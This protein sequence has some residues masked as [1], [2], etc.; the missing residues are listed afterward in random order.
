MQHGLLRFIIRTLQRTA[1]IFG[2]HDQVYVLCASCE[3]DSR[4]ALCYPTLLIVRG[5]IRPNDTEAARRS[6]HCT[7]SLWSVVSLCAVQVC[8]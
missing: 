8:W 3:G 5:V 2:Q 7:D 6:V 4:T 1:V